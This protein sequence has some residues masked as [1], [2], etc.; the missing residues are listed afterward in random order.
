MKTSFKYLAIMLAMAV[1]VFTG[2]KDLEKMQKMADQVTL[3][4]STSPVEMHGDSI[5]IKLSGSFP[6]KF[7]QKKVTLEVTPILKYGGQEIAFKSLTMQGED[8]E[9][10][11]KVIPFESGG[12]FEIADKIAYDPA[13]REATLVVRGNATIKDESQ[14]VLE[15]EV[16]PGVMATATLLDFTDA[17]VIKAADNFE[18]VT[19]DSKGAKI[20]FLINRYNIR[21]RELKKDEIKA[22]NDYIKEVAE[23]ENMK[24]ENI[25]IDA[26][27]SPD[28]TVK[29]NT[30]LS[31]N[32]KK[33]TEKYIGKEV[34]SAKLD[35]G[36]EG[37]V[38][39]ARS[40]A[41]DWEGFKTELQKSDV[42]DKDLI[43]R[44][45]SMYN[46]PKVREKEIKNISAAF[47][48][49]KDDVLPQLRRSEFKVKVAITGFSDEEISKYALEKPDTLDVEE[50]LYAG[51][52]TDDL[53]TLK[54]IY[55]TTTQQF[56]DDWRGH[57]N[58]GV[59]NFQQ[60][61]YADA[62]TSFNAAKQIESNNSKVL[63]NLGATS[64]AQ[65][66]IDKAEEYLNAATAGGNH[67]SYNQAL[68]ATKKGD[69]DKAIDMFASSKFNT[70]NFA[71]AKLLQY[72]LTKNEQ[73]Y[74]AALGILEKVD[75]KEN[76]IWYYLK[77]VIGARKQDSDML[78]NNLRTAIEKNADLKQ[79]AKT[80]VEFIRYKED[81]T[82]K[83]I[84]E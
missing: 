2:C 75:N 6:A 50:L 63:N 32:R 48:Q 33:I 22:L 64:L 57:N 61:N 5:Q 39:N 78:F 82:F 49:L 68:I 65:G 25:T 76:P 37:N 18:R 29:L 16:A 43:L 42:Q 52:L 67:A 30:K 60:G 24:V 34:K 31:E 12:S 72:S 55:T 26:Y 47:N 54:K 7:F 38:Y 66:E 35:L 3:S 36:E 44:V 28:G 74:D 80:D 9:A 46:D 8:V 4:V 40:V 58:L 69:Y 77:S 62:M 51:T 27:A 71:L 23:K 53:E 13:M 17:K 79:T 70:V 56:S 59:I 45:L 81:G 73:A 83:S 20:Q 41:E 84:I 19:Y 11:N 14:A 15:R 21:G 10:N 1:L